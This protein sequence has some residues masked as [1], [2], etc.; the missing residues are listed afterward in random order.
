MSNTLTDADMVELSELGE[1]IV[2]G[3]ACD[4]NGSGLP[5]RSDRIGAVE[6]MKRYLEI[7]DY[8]VVDKEIVEQLASLNIRING[9]KVI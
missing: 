1:R 6:D 2:L 3:L 4:A 8:T 7:H 9:V 5:C